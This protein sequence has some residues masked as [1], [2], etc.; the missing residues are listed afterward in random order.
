VSTAAAEDVQRHLLAEPIDYTSVLDAF[1]G[2]KLLD[3]SVGVS[4]RRRQERSTITRE[5]SGMS[6]AIGGRTLPV[7]QSR[8]VTTSLSLDLA[9]GVRHD[10]MV[11]GRRPLV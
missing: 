6:D 2:D 10:L 7:L 4:F 11:Y 9:V 3:V 8:E 5:R 1:E